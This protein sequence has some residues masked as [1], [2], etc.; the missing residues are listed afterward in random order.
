MSKMGID[1]AAKCEIVLG[2]TGSRT[3]HI[4]EMTPTEAINLLKSLNGKS[5]NY[6]PGKKL[7]MKR[8]VLAIAHELGWEIEGTTKVDMERVNG[9]CLT[10]SA[11]KKRFD[12]LNLK[13]LESVVKQFGLMRR[14]YL[15]K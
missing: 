5:D 12:D 15:K 1:E 11:A 14:A 3:S 13:E 8:K 4:S 10:K 9:Y 7:K 6:E 2:A